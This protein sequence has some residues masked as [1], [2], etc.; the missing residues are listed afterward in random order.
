MSNNEAQVAEQP[1][2]IRQE[3]KDATQEEFAKARTKG[4]LSEIAEQLSIEVTGKET[5]AEL[6]TAIY[7]KFPLPDPALRGKSESSDPVTAVWELAHNTFAEA[8]DPDAEGYVKPRRK[9]IVAAGQA[10]GIA[11]YTVRTQY[12]SWFKYTL[13]GSNMITAD[14]EGLPKGLMERIFPEAGEAA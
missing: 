7:A 14:S 9:D 1:V 3:C 12:Q 4:V 5:K 13:G 10:M 2:S 11:Y 6:V 8:G